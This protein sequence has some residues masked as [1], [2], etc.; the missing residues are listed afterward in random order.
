MTDGY[1]ETTA[2]HIKLATT[3]MVLGIVS[4]EGDAM[5]FHFFP[6]GIRVNARDFNGEL[7]GLAKRSWTMEDRAHTDKTLRHHIRTGRPKN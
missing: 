6:Q 7:Q 2:M 1:A 5:P 3:V 4:K